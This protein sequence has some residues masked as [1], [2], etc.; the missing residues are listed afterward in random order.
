MAHL[1]SAG[2]IIT[3]VDGVSLFNNRPHI[4]IKV[5]LKPKQNVS[6]FSFEKKNEK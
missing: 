5:S 1:K 2:G 6:T 3:G 4:D